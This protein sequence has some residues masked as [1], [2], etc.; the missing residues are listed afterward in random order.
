VDHLLA[1]ARALAD[2][3][4]AN[5]QS[6]PAASSTRPGLG[7]SPR[8]ACAWRSPATSSASSISRVISTSGRN[9]SP[10]A[11]S[12]ISRQEIPKALIALFGT[13]TR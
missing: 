12:A 4:A 8:L 11:V 5:D 2:R 13:R 9:A 10:A 1:Q 7:A 6:L 3:W